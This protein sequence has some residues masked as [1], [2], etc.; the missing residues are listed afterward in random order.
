MV[1]LN[2]DDDDDDDDGMMKI[3]TKIGMQWE[4]PWYH[5]L[6]VI[7]GIAIHKIREMMINPLDCFFPHI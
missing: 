7:W 2:D 6:F 5:R 3:V 1:A 4:V